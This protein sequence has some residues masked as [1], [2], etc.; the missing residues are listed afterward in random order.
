M[1]GRSSRVQMYFRC[2]ERV[3]DGERGESVGQ[4]GIGV[5][6]SG[7]P[8]VWIG[9]A[10]DFDL[11][12]V[13]HELWLSLVVDRSHSNVV[14]IQLVSHSIDHHNCFIA[15]G[16]RP[17]LLALWNSQSVLP[18]EVMRLQMIHQNLSPFPLTP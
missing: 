1:A 16:Y 11:D 18:Y 4:G 12:E 3:V 14:W 17:R 15:L 2:A 7:G 13:W 5:V 10:E 6:D 8:V 9:A